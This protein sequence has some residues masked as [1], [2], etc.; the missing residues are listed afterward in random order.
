MLRRHIACQGL[1][2]A[3]PLRNK[4][5]DRA[6]QKPYIRLRP[7]AYVTGNKPR[8]SIGS[9]PER[10]A[11]AHR[12]KPGH[13]SVP[14]PCLGQGIPCPGTSLW[15]ARTLLGGIRT[16]SKGPGTLTWDSR[17]VLGG[18]GLCVQGSDASS[19]RSGPTDCILGYI[20]FSGH[21]AHLEPSTWWGRVL[22]TAWLEIVARAPCLHTVVRGTPESL[23]QGTDINI[24]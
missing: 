10:G 9:P 20:I 16:P 11:Q 4:R 7:L 15:V 5:R 2:A 21:A 19:W 18:F 13:V 22:F 17:T 3:R 1:H 23:I 12:I 6:A 14:D 8:G 24:S